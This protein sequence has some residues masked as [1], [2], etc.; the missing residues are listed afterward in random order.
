MCSSG[1]PTDQLNSIPRLVSEP[2]PWRKVKHTYLQDHELEHWLTRYWGF[3]GNYPS[4]GTK[5]FMNSRDV[6]VRAAGVVRRLGQGNW[7][8]DTLRACLLRKILHSSLLFP[9]GSLIMSDWKTS[10][11]IG[12]YQRNFNRS[13][14]ITHLVRD[15]RLIDKRWAL[16]HGDTFIRMFSI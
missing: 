13:Y 10:L 2:K 9:D 15:G 12:Q 8:H 11:G 3:P 6:E 5:G 1:L 14:S 16:N 7:H 4:A